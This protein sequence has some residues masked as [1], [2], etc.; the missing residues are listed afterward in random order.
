MED[1]KEKTG[2]QEGRYKILIERSRKG[3]TH[4]SVYSSFSFPLR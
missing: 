2:E 4:Y 3:I 1:M